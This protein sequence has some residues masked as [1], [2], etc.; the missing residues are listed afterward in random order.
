[1]SVILWKE[2]VLESLYLC[3]QH[4]KKQSWL[5]GKRDEPVSIFSSKVVDVSAGV[6]WDFISLVC[7][8]TEQ[9]FRQVQNYL[10]FAWTGHMILTKIDGWDFSLLQASNKSIIF[11]K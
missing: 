2:I 4:E 6:D 10:C 7:A 3:C 5:S 8:V 1:M 9:G 11:S